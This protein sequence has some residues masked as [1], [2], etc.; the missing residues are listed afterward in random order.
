MTAGQVLDLPDRSVSE[1]TSAHLDAGP[2]AHDALLEV[3]QGGVERQL[4]LDQQGRGTVPGLSAGAITVGLVT[5]DAQAW[6]FAPMAPVAATS[7]TARS[8]ASLLAP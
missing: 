6:R 2:D 4:R 5:T 7:A 1:A 8:A 3:E